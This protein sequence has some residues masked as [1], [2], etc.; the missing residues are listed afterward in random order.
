VLVYSADRKWW[1]PVCR[2]CWQNQRRIHLGNDGLARER[3]TPLS[4]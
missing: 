1:P 3:A 2:P 4:L